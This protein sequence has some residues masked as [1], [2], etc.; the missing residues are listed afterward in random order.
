MGVERVKDSAHRLFES[1][2]GLASSPSSQSALPLSRAAGDD[3]SLA[4]IVG[5]ADDSGDVCDCRDLYRWISEDLYKQKT[6]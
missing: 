6:A 2:E 3:D 1:K 4:D 5:G